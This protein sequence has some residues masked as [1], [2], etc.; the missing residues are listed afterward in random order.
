MITEE[1]PLNFLQEKKTIESLLKLYEMT[2][3]LQK[4][5]YNKIGNYGQIEKEIGTIDNLIK[6]YEQDIL[7]FQTKFAQK[8]ELKPLKIKIDILI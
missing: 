6:Q 8:V 4:E 7:E 2:D 1:I 5:N 3:F